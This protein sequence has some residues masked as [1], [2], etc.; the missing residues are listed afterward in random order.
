MD[1][2]LKLDKPI[3]CRGK[4]LQARIPNVI[5]RKGHCFKGPKLS[6]SSCRF[7]PRRQFYFVPLV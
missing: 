6:Q 5:G 7:H 3:I 2:N 4:R 1:S